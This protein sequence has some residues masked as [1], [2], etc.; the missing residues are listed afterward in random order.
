M[1]TTT[2]IL[3]AT[4]IVGF[5]MAWNIGANDTA[6]SMAS[7]VGAK[8][9]TLKQA[10]CIDGVF[11]LIGAV[12][13][14]THVTNTVRKGI[15]DPCLM[16]T[17]QVVMIAFFAAILG[18]SLWVTIATWKGLPVSTTHAIVGAIMGVG[19]ISGGMSAIQWGKIWGIVASWVISPIFSG[20]LAYSVFKLISKTIL[21]KDNPVLFAKRYSPYFIGVTFFIISLSFLLKT[22][23]GK[24]LNISGSDGIFVALIFGAL[25]GYIGYNL[26]IRNRKIQ[27]VEQIFKILQII[28]SC[29][30][31]FAVG[32]N[33]VANAVGPIAAVWNIAV[34]GEIA[35]KVPVPFLLLALGGIGIVIG[36]LTWGYKI[37]KTVG[38]KITELTNTRGFSIDFGAATSVLVASKLGCPVSTTHAVVGAVIGVGLARGL[39]AIDLR[40]IKNI[41]IS[42]VI[43]LPVAAGIA[44]LIFT[45]LR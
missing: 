6:N 45:L 18:A 27:N 5:Y 17:P 12:F 2:I 26:F 15:A 31:G 19:M 44:M 13:V 23:L 8:A 21:Q 25:T 43:T 30:V 38:F 4:A 36:T 7:A 24:T 42:W 28:T 35:A 29:Y 16:G 33:D 41:A 11:N 37:I 32:A 20:I 39:D 34:T 40:V 14:G 22:P 9:L 1:G 10:V 3:I